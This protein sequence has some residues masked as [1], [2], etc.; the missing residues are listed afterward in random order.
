LLVVVDVP[1][2]LNAAILHMTTCCNPTFGTVWGW[3]SHSQNGIWESSRT[4]KT[5]EFDCRG[6]NT[7]P[8]VVLH[9]IRKLLKCRCRKWPRMN[10]LD[11]CS[12]SYGKNK[13]Q[14]T[15]NH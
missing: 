9:A 11:I 2:M 5:S 3:H 13:G 1:I 4:P 10:H 7:S 12:T 6:Q 8:W 14:E 15:P